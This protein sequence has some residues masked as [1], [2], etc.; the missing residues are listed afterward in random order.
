MFGSDRRRACTPS[1]SRRAWQ[2]EDS[3]DDKQE[4][5]GR[6]E[7]CRQG[8]V[9]L[10]VPLMLSQTSPESLPGARMGAFA[11]QGTSAQRSVG[12]PERVSEPLVQGAIRRNS[13]RGI[14]SGL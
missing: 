5:P 8:P 6:M 14:R 3:L 2:A 11:L 7:D 1:M 13:C 9:P 12:T 10:I 4:L